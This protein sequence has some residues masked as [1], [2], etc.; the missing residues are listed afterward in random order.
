M[1]ILIVDDDTLIRNWLSMLLTQLKQYEIRIFEAT[2]GIEALELCAKA[3][4]DLVIT[5]IKMPQLNGID[6]IRRLKNEYPHI[7][8]SVLS[9]YDDF[10]YVRIALKCGA[11]DYIL[12]AEMKIED[13]SG[14]LEKT[15]NDFKIEKSLQHGSH[16]NY[17][18]TNETKKKFTNYLENKNTSCEQFLSAIKPPLT[19]NHLCISIFK[20]NVTTIADVPVFI[21]S[22][23]C[24]NTMKGEKI[25][26]ITFPWNKDYFVL[27][28]NC[29]D[30]INEHQKEEYLKLLSILDK[31]LEKYVDTPISYSINL[32]C[33]KDD[34][35]RLKFSDAVDIM[36]YRHYYSLSVNIEEIITE[37]HS[38]R[39]ELV[40]S[41]Q[42]LLDIGDHQQAITILLKHLAY[43]H[44]IYVAPKK[45]KSFVTAAMNIFL[46]HATLLDSQNGFA[47]NMESFLDTIINSATAEDVQDT[48]EHFFRVYIEQVLCSTQ[49]ISNTIKLAVDYINENCS[50]KIILDDVAAHV[51]LN[52]SYL[53]QLFKKEMGIS[54]GDYLEKVRIDRAKQLIRS[55]TKSMSEIA[56]FVGFSNQNYFTKVFKKVT[57]VSPLKYKKH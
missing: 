12:K 3:P 53:S 31:N 41:I 22:D 19:M 1:N 47:E 27:M 43:V 28:Y 32:I 18:A 52:R 40:G 10:D 57:G 23:I 50:K 29:T 11:L 15:L 9:S 14:L 54:F 30:T 48:I 7:R 45:V 46:T 44:S 26:G 51:F 56:G 16:S 4:I 20:T 35:L 36:S 21:I 5:D 55:S 2:D 42:K 13:I 38:G 33:K 37:Q 34:E 8:T 6:L 24:N 17:S 49:N 39:K 25:N